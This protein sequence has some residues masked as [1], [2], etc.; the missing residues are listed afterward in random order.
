MKCHVLNEKGLNLLLVVGKSLRGNVNNFCV[1]V[2]SIF[3]DALENAIV[4]VS[5]GRNV[6]IEDTKGSKFIQ[7]DSM[8]RVVDEVGVRSGHGE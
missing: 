4:L 8:R 5:V 6:P 1:G 3:A 7:G 2:V